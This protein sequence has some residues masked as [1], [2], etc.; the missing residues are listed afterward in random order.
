MRTDF[1]WWAGAAGAQTPGG[2]TNPISIDG[3]DDEE[4]ESALT[5]KEKK[6][7]EWKRKFGQFSAFFLNSADVLAS[8]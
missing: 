3:D 7:R 1:S 4:D 8:P 5:E 6:R 2:N